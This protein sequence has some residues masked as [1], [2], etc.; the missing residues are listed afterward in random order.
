MPQCPPPKLP[1][2]SDFQKERK[3]SFKEIPSQM[4]EEI[5]KITDITTLPFSEADMPFWP[6]QSC[7]MN[8]QI[9]TY[10]FTTRESAEI[11]CINWL[12]GGTR[13]VWTSSPT[14]SVF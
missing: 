8:M 12:S 7:C 2:P 5:R 3:F 14:C 9:K 13:I 10:R 6:P 4:R 11:K 1:L